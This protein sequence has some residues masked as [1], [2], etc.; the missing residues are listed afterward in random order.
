MLQNFL[1]DVAGMAPSFTIECRKES[2]IKYIRETVG[3]SKVLVL[4]S[5]GV[6]S[7]VCAALLTRAVSADQ[8]FA[9]HIDNGA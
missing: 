4:V 3:T 9:V 8:I 5:G 2:C 7:T 6:D 1:V